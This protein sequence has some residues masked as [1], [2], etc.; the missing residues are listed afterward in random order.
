[1]L[2]DKSKKIFFETQSVPENSFIID[3]ISLIKG[4]PL[5]KRMG[6][7]ST[8]DPMNF[9]VVHDYVYELGK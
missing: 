7:P 6:T 9:E 3:N 8:H 5:K 4:T 2:K 1:M